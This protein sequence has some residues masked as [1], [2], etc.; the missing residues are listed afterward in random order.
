MTDK[1]NPF[2]CRAILH[3]PGVLYRHAVETIKTCDNKKST[4]ENPYC[5]KPKIV[6]GKARGKARDNG[7][8]YIRHKTSYVLYKT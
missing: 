6:I 5:M 4:R 1:I 3:N 8:S 2:K 7:Q